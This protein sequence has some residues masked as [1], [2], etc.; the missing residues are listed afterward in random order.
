MGWIK[1]DKKKTVEKVKEAE[2][3]EKEIAETKEEV[4]ELKEEESEDEDEEEDTE[5]VV[6]WSAVKIATQTEEV[7]Y[8]S[9][10]KT[11]LSLHQAIAEI[12]NRTEE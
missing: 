3:L 11:Q 10:S 2:K 1:K 9:K 12:L 7:I 8:E 6:D 5:Q 4:K